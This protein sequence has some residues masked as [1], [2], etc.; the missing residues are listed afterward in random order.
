MITW[1]ASSQLNTTTKNVRIHKYVILV[2][3]NEHDKSMSLIL[4]S[5][6]QKIIKTTLGW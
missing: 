2:S 6:I 4:L 3:Q 5:M 1:K